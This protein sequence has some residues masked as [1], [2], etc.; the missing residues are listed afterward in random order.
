L[1]VLQLEQAVRT[2]AQPFVPPQRHQVVAREALARPQLARRPPAELAAVVVAREEE[3]VGDLTAEAAGNVDELDEANDGGA[4][5][6]ESLAADGRSFGLDDLGL[7]VDDQPQGPPHRHHREGLE[8]RVEREAA[9]S[10]M[11]LNLLTR[12]K[13]CS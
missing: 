9:H 7:M 11:L 8:R 13:T 12:G 1:R 10:G 3:G 2:L 5:Q 4:R 6:R